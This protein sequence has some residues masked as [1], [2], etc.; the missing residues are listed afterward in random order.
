[1][2]NQSSF[3]VLEAIRPKPGDYPSNVMKNIDSAIFQILT[4]EV[5]NILSASMG[6]RT[7]NWDT[8]PIFVR[9]YRRP[10]K[11]TFVLTV[12]PGMAN[13]KGYQLWKWVSRGTKRTGFTRAK[14]APMLVFQRGYHARTLKGNKYGRTASRYGDWVRAIAVPISSIEGRHFEEYVVKE[15]SGK[16][17]RIITKA[18]GDAIRRS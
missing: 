5:K 3:I 11:D 15:E 17:K 18:V 12:R 7:A 10:N 6:R 8:K 2:G 16:V 1:M 4:H 14:K 13:K 9:D